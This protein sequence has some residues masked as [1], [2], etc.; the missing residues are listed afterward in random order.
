M[1]PAR[2][3]GMPALF[4]R[5]LF[6]QPFL[7]RQLIERE[8][9]DRYKGAA[10]E[11]VWVVVNPLLLLA[12]YGFVFGV[13]FK[14]RF[15]GLADAPEV[16][17][18]LVLFSGLIVHALMAE[19]LSRAPSLVVQHANYVKKVVF[20]LEVL[21]VVVMGGAL[22]HAAIAVAILLAGLVAFGHPPGWTALL[23]PVVWLPLVLLTLG[24][25][26][27]LASLGVFL[28]DIDQIIR[29]AIMLLLFVSPVFYPVEAVPEALR[30][31]LHLNPLTPVIEATRDVLLW[32][33]LPDPA[34]YAG[35]LALGLFVA[36]HGLYWFARTK[37]S[38]ADVV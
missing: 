14:A 36:W 23:L 34:S 4:W 3:L 5:T 30:P 8:I 25:T 13:V 29:L 31:L 2:Y 35:G 19:C 32:G 10:L 1:T 7:M 18:P 37:H 24:L 33:R 38:F 9:R 20:P 27:F 15:P 6:G 28:R 17:Y 22:F 16:A 26:W 21:P 11:L 12:I